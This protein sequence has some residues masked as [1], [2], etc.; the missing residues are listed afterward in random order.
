MAGSALNLMNLKPP[1]PP[2]PVKTPTMPTTPKS[3]F[4]AMGTPSATPKVKKPA[5]KAVAKGKAA[6]TSPTLVTSG[7]TGLAGALAQKNLVP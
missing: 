1:K 5:V 7:P 3:T 6:T 2:A 4:P